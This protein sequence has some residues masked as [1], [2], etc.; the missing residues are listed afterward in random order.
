MIADKV[1][2]KPGEVGARCEKAPTLGDFKKRGLNPCKDMVANCCGA[3]IGTVGGAVMTVETC[4]IRTATK[5]SYQ[6]P[7]TPLQTTWP[8]AKDWNWKCIS[9][10]SQ[11]AGAA[12]ALVASA[13]MMA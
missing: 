8:A 4:Q 3:A 5:W 6:A 7:R 2:A 1:V 11:A 12:V 9:G 13:Y 10:A